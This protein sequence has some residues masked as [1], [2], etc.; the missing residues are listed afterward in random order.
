MKSFNCILILYKAIS[1][2]IGLYYNIDTV[3]EIPFQENAVGKL[4]SQYEVYTPHGYLGKNSYDIAY[5]II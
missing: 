2:L 3:K 1:Y 5:K 4:L